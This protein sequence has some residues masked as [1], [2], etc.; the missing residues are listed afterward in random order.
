MGQ[1]P[2]KL[3]CKYF[4][5]FRVA[6]KV[7]RYESF[8]QISVM[9]ASVGLVIVDGEKNV[10]VSWIGAYPQILLTD[11]L[12]LHDTDEKC[13]NFGRIASAGKS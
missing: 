2:W 8:Q 1:I 12:R 4:Y 11:E 13:N 6:D 9:N 5:T 3:S 10:S 7:I